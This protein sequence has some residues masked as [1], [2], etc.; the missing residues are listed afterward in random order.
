MPPSWRSGTCSVSRNSVSGSCSARPGRWGWGDGRPG[1][2]SPIKGRSGL[3]LYRVSYSQSQRFEDLMHALAGVY[4]HEMVLVSQ[5]VEL[6]QQRALVFDEAGVS[7]RLPQEV[8]ARLPVV[9][10]PVREHARQQVVH[11]NGTMAFSMR[12]QKSVA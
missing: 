5:V 12:S 6:R 4:R 8:L 2:L 10:L 1:W 3:A 9:Q 11:V 7:V